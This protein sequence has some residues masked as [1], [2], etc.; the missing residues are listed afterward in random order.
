MEQTFHKFMQHKQNLTILTLQRI[1]TANT[2]AIAVL[3]TKQLQNF[4]NINAISHD[5]T[6]NYQTNTVLS[7]NFYNRT[8]IDA[9]FTN[10]YTSTQ[11]D[12]NLSTNYQTN[13][14]LSVN[15]YN[16]SEVDTTFSNYY[17]ITQ[18]Q[19]NYYD[20]TC[21][22]A[23]IGGGGYSDTDIDN[24]LDLR[25]PKSD[26]TNRF[27][28]NPIID[29]SAPTVIHSG[30]TLNSSTIN[31]SPVAGL[32]FS[33]QTGGGDKVVSQFNNASNYLT[34][35]G[36]KIIANA[37]SDDS[38]TA[39]DLN[40]SD[41]VKIQ[42]LTLGDITVPTTGSD[43]IRNSGDANYTL[44]VRDTQGVWE[45]RNR[46]LRCMNPSNPANGTE[47]ILH[48]T[49]GDYRLRIGSQ[50]TAQVGIGVQYNSSYFLNVGGVSNFNQARAATDLEVIGN[51][52]LTNIAGDI[53]LPT[54]GVDM[55]RNS[56]D[57][58]YNLRVRDTQ[59]VFEFK[60]GNFRCMNP[61]NP[62][63]GTEMIL[64]DTGGDYRLRIGSTTT[65]TVG[66]GRQ[67][68]ASYH[69]TVGGTSNFNETRVENDATF[70][71]Q[72]LLST[73]GRIFQRADAN[74]QTDRTTDPTTGT[75]A[76]QLNDTNGITI[77][78]AVTN[79]QTFNS[80]GKITAEADLDVWGGVYFQHSSAIKET[81]NGS[82]YDLDIRNGDTDRAINF[83]I[84]TIGS[85]PE[86]SLSEA[87][88]TLLGNLEIT[89]DDITGQQRV[90]I[91][92]PDDNGWIR[93][94][95]NNLSTLDATT[96]GVDVYGDLSYTGSLIPP[97]YKRLKK[98]IKEVNSKKAVEL[99][100]YIKPK[101]YHFNDDRQQGKSRIGFIANDF[102]ETKKMPDEW[103]NVVKEGK[104]GYLKFDYTTC[105]PIL[106]SALQTTINEVDKLKKEANKL[107][108]NRS[109]SDLKILI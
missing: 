51:L 4:N 7:S 67:Y 85:T 61:S 20:K 78:R 43:I 96:T 92:N 5:L 55:F 45:F 84:G 64:H 29:C 108:K 70:L 53:Q 12:T 16:K 24:L 95:S 94:S 35:Q 41:S 74:L 75:I 68:N 40:P 21:I 105:V 48:D 15:Y 22:D 44:R 102:M 65:A 91:N 49:R 71:E 23:N 86:L 109:D 88:V 93:L 83:I 87:K 63:N 8:E 76:L 98:D 42:S 77:N 103:Q 28:A 2:D 31:I 66:I 106:W 90:L 11:I 107:K 100:K 36:N 37:T 54:T 58:N 25:V 46:N 34:L 101:T 47:M 32:L 79:N 6:N 38:L 18:T 13:A 89:H 80:I 52:N 1:I 26:F 39:L 60:N 14:Q 56:G 30:L 69:L 33:N 27:S 81:L 17:T 19:A 82:D 10:Y 97:S 3:N 57:S 73:N 99:I 9:T 104:D 59:G 62:A 50:T 72:H